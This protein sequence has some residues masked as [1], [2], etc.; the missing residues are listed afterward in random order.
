MSMAETPTAFE[1]IMK[2]AE[3]LRAVGLRELADPRR[4]ALPLSTDEVFA[5]LQH[6]GLKEISAVF[7]QKCGSAVF[8]RAREGEIHALSIA[9]VSDRR[10]LQLIAQAILGDY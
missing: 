2:A 9:L 5:I 6:P 3:I 7:E 1:E 8:D 4:A 10:E